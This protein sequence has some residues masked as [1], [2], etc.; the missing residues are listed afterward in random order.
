MAAIN[1]AALNLL[2]TPFLIPDDPKAVWL[3]DGQPHE[4]IIDG[5]RIEL[6]LYDEASRLNL[7]S[8]P[9]DQLIALIEV[10]QTEAG[11]DPSQGDQIADAIMDWRDA[12]DLAQL[13]G[14][15]DADYRDE[16]RLFGAGDRMF[17]SVEELKQVLGMTQELYQ[18]LAP[19]LTV[20][21]TGGQPSQ[22]FASAEVLAVTQGLLLEDARQ[23]VLQRE[24]PLLPDA[25]QAAL[26]S[27]R[28]GPLYRALITQRRAQGT[29]RSMQALLRVPGLSGSPFQ[30]LWRRYGLANSSP[31]DAGYTDQPNPT[32]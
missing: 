29:G 19:H 22:T 17:R 26:P 12:D 20:T 21:E 28:G 7:N 23:V 2:S 14:A 25:G 4:L 5:E 10:T 24:Q 32:L 15:E 31:V 9:R 18:G 3:P 13:N 27:E 6:R 11:F 30:V 8:V 1:L 16:G